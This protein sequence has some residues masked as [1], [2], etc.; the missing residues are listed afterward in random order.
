MVIKTDLRRVRLGHL[1]DVLRRSVRDALDRLGPVAFPPRHLRVELVAGLQLLST[2]REP[3]GELF[4]L[5]PGLGPLSDQT[6]YRLQARLPAIPGVPVPEPMFQVVPALGQ[7]CGT[8]LL[9]DGRGPVPGVSVALFRGTR[10]GIIEEGPFPTVL[11]DDKGAF[12]FANVPIE[13]W[14]VVVRVD[15]ERPWLEQPA[16]EITVGPGEMV[17]GEFVVSYYEGAVDQ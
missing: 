3:G 12:R 11:T 15:P 17:E 10:D 9:A 4:A 14:V 16:R 8:V 13:S 5:L 6:I 7:V 1:G 2:P